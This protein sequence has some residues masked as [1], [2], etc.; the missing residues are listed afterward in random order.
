MTDRILSQRN[1]EINKILKSISSFYNEHTKKLVYHLYNKH[2]YSYQQ[3]AEILDIT[4]QRVF[5]VFPK[6]KI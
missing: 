1:E 5:R 3:V 4:K 2:N 6:E